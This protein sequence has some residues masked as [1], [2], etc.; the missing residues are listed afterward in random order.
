MRAG[1]WREAQRPF[2]SFDHLPMK[3][4]RLVALRNDERVTPWALATLETRPHSQSLNASCETAV[5]ANGG[6]EMEHQAC[7][8]WERESV[9]LWLLEAETEL[10]SAQRAVEQRRPCAKARLATAR[11]EL[12][13][14]SAAAELLLTF[15]PSRPAEA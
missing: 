12:A 3:T 5:E 15:N 14:A 7:V 9:A 2:L 8:S 11:R 4:E 1:A 10:R 13:L 6:R